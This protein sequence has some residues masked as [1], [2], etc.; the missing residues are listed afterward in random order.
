LLEGAVRG[1]ANRLPEDIDQPDPWCL[2]TAGKTGGRGEGMRSGCEDFQNRAA[3]KGSLTPEPSAVPAGVVGLGLMGTSIATCLL[4][5]GH[6]VVGVELDPAKRRSARR[7]VFSLLEEMRR[8][9]LL[10]SGPAQVINRL[11][12]SEG[13]SG[14]KYCEVVVESIIESVPAKKQVIRKV[15]E[16]VSPAALLGSNTSAIPV[17][18]LQEGAL[19]PERVLGIHWAEPAHVTR[20]MEIIC[21]K[22]TDPGSADRALALARRWGKE[23]SVLRRD[24]RG[25]L[26]NRIMY[27]MLREAF[28]LVESGY[29]T[30]AD[31]DRS[32]RNDLGYWITFAGP[33]R[34]MDLTGIP[35]YEEV[36]R[37][38]LPDLCRDTKVPTLISDLVK[39]GARGVANARG[40]YPYTPTQARRWEKLFLKF[41]YEIRALAQKYPEDIGDRP[42]Q[43]SE[44]I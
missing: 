28:Y 24:V 36:M 43:R 20:F 14:L 37:D 30:I 31:I 26:T 23:P 42:G 13:Y 44:R 7:R 16:V 12:I 38:L 32:L 27:A 35:A 2:L 39:S 8:E 41:S 25:F 5:A 9:R 4:A 29:A 22:H 11:T 6:Q 40:F 34:Y 10:K 1:S 18:S 19:H 21:G 33:F 15:E 17:T 3:K